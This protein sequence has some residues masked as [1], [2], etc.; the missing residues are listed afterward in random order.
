MLLQ[1]CRLLIRNGYFVT[2]VCEKEGPAGE[3]F[4]ESGA[5]VIID[6]LLLQQHHTL[7][8]FAQNFDHVVCNTA[9]TWPV[10]QQLNKLTHTIWWI[11]EAK[12]LESFVVNPGF[13]ATLTTTATVV[14]VSE[15]ALQYI[16]RYNA[17]AKKIYYGYEDIRIE[18]LSGSRPG[19]PITSNASPAPGRRK[20]SFSIIGSIE[21]RKGQDILIRALQSLDQETRENIEIKLV[22]RPHDMDFYQELLRSIG[23]TGQDSHDLTITGETDHQ[24][25]LEIMRRSD[26]IICP[27]R[28]D[29]FPVVIVEALCLGKPCIVSSNT[30]FSELIEDGVNGYIIPNEDSEALAFKIRH[31]VDYPSSLIP[32]ARAAR[33]LYEQYLNLSDFEEKFLALLTPATHPATEI[34]TE[35][36]IE[37]ATGTAT[38]A[39]TG[40][41]TAA[42][43]GA[44]TE[45]ATGAATGTATHPATGAATETADRR[46]S[47]GPASGRKEHKNTLLC[48]D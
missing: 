5:P 17:A 41:V 37:I 28:D 27:S 25:C 45:P 19:L 44:A 10:I 34:S 26:V 16:R 1:L 33:Q 22:G 31:I 36:A 20:L 30:G 23:A 4:L 3:L 18:D 13:V 15:Y 38:E 6:S 24:D 32:M 43:T 9:V 35:T 46:Q 12:V 29:P 42:A 47:S 2:V 14:S 39:A 11:H 48:E 21:P 40:A 8:R 7:S